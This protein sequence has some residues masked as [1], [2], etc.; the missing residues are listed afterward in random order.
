MSTESPAERREF[1]FRGHVQGVGFRATAASLARRHAVT[2]FVRN[3]ADGSVEIA[4]EG[5]GPAIERFIGEVRAVFASH[6]RDFR[7]SVKQ[8]TG[9]FDEFEVRY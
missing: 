5:A 8:P 7:E 2:G 3:L 6:I 1:V 9:E 4:A